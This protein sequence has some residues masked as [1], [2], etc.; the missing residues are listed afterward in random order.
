MKLLL[1]THLVLWAIAGPGQLPAKAETLIEDPDNEVVVSAI[2]IWEIAIK[3]SLRRGSPNDM[4]ISGA[5]ALR[6][7]QAAGYTFLPITPE[8]AAAV[9]DLPP[10]HQDPFDRMLVA[11]A[12]VEPLRL[13]TRDARMAA[14]GAMVMLV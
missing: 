8:H 4:P 2:S 12:T 3:Y 11:Q 9:D 13:L 1:D 10:H 6:H 5:E 7:C 14:Y